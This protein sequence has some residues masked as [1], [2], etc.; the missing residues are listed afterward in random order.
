MYAV[1]TRDAKKGKKYKQDNVMT[2]K[3]YNDIVLA[4]IVKDPNMFEKIDSNY[5]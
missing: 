5:L 4:A 1:A 2:A 3:N